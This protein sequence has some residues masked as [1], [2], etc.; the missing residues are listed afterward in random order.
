MKRFWLKGE[1][2]AAEDSHITRRNINSIFQNQ[3]SFTIT[4]L[5]FAAVITMVL[6]LFLLQ[7]FHMASRMCVE[8]KKNADI[9]R[10]A[11]AALQCMTREL[12]SLYV[13][14]AIPLL[15]NHPD[16]DAILSDIAGQRQGDTIFFGTLMPSEFNRGKGDLCAAGYYCVSTDTTY[17]LRRFF[18]NS[19]QVFNALSMHGVFFD[20]SEFTEK[21]NGLLAQNVM[22]LRIRALDAWGNVY[23]NWPTTNSPPSQIEISIDVQGSPTPRASRSALAFQTF[24]VRVGKD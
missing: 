22:N 1:R 24:T 11:R 2:F 7:M 16:A 14:D 9:C 19:D 20:K 6:L 12:H 17:S 3:R 8:G 5:L 4:E 10:E 18:R 15:I 13:G 21:N 23:T